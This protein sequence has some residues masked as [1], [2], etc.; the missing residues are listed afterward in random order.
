MA[1][2]LGLDDDLDG[3]EVVIEIEKAF[4]VKI[5][6]REAEAILNVGQM[7]DLLLRKIPPNVADGKCASAMAFY[8]LRRAIADV[9]NEKKFLPNTDLSF[10]EKGRTK[11]SYK[12]LE[13]LTS[14]RLPALE[15]SPTA[16]VGCL[17][18]VCAFVVIA[19]LGLTHVINWPGWTMLM[20]L[21]AGIAVLY[22]DPGRIPTEC[23]TL[24]G[25]AEKAAALNY[26]KFI[27]LGASHR[28]Q[29]IWTNLAR[30]LAERTNLPEGEITRETFFLQSQLK[31]AAKKAA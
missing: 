30:V 13:K 12:R 5:E 24:S 4:G 2:T 16:G 29:D 27:K 26:G 25:L 14:L 17:L 18:S 23:R 1:N 28:E 21:G 7:Y 19:V 20:A 10:L 22:V 9:G 15:V 31:K 11:T 6:N 8:R 3:V